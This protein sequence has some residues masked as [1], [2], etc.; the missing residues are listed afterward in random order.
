[1]ISAGDYGI[2]V[3]L[4]L[5]WYPRRSSLSSPP[6]EP[7]PPPVIDS[8]QVIGASLE[9]LF[10]PDGPELLPLTFTN[11]ND[12]SVDCNVDSG[13][14]ITDRNFYLHIALRVR[15][16]VRV[17]NLIVPASS[18]VSV[19]LNVT[20]DDLNNVGGST[21][22]TGLV[23]QGV[24]QTTRDLEI[25]GGTPQRVPSPAGTVNIINYHIG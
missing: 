16:F 8:P 14:P 7:P 5:T 10:G 18:N 25:V 12:I 9:R 11:N 20:P 1:M 19:M 22:N 2:E 3:Q 4:L 6:P 15:H 23:L 24:F 21:Q 13:R 17:K